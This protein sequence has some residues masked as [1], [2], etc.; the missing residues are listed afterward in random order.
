M[1]VYRLYDNKTDRYVGEE[2]SFL[3]DAVAIDIYEQSVRIHYEHREDLMAVMQ[4][5]GELKLIRMNEDGSRTI[6]C[7]FFYS[8]GMASISA[9]INKLPGTN[10]IN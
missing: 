8:P 2:R 4:Q 1:H 7:S 3:T 10:V 9:N 5:A 6:V